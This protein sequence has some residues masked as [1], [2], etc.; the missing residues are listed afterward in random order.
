[1]TIAT[2]RLSAAFAARVATAPPGIIAYITAGFPGHD[3]TVD[4]LFAC[5]R[6][7]C[8]AAEVGIPFSDP[9]ADGPTVQRAGWR[10]L[11]QGMT[12]AT[13]IDQVA[14]ARGRGLTIP[15]VVMTYVNPMLSIGADRFAASAAAAGVDGAILT[16]LPAD[17]AVDAARALEARGLALIP[18]VAP[19]TPTD[20]IARIA[21]NA[22]GFIYCVS[23]TG[24]TG[25]RNRV[26]DRALDLLD[27]V[28]SVS[29]L[30]RA[31]G[32]GISRP[33]HVA[34]LRGRCEAAVVGSAL[35]SAIEAGGDPSGVA[36]GFLRELAG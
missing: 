14:E 2:S 28:R 36:E 13:A 20:R 5:E 29:P 21:A 3:D 24:V 10:A 11:R 31:L 32:F 1:M 4:L 18:L 30:P 17:E 8:L 19:T 33:D 34:S 35:L 9:L 25:A 23:V 22:A 15:I 12:A 6:A 26:D 16:D 7:G 27:R